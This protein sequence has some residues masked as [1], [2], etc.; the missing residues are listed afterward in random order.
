MKLL[1]VCMVALIMLSPMAFAQTSE[2]HAKPLTDND[3]KLLRED[4]QSVKDDVIKH[5][6]Q[7]TPAEAEKFWPLYREYAREQGKIADER[8][9]LLTDYAKNLDQMDDGKA[10]S[11]TERFLRIQDDK[12]S[13]DK[14]Y[15]PKF[16]SA[17][18]AKRAAKF[19]QV[20][21]RLTMMVDVQLAS[22]IPL[23]P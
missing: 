19:Y 18:G 21:N 10:T 20:N 5:T 3:I 6:M 23:I 12:Q 22:D 14:R 16:V 11:L 17:L 8:L 13:L 4:V 1:H 2:V 7:F 15:F 9:G